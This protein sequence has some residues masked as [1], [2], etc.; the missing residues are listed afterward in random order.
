MATFAVFGV[1]AQ[2]TYNDLQNIC[3]GAAC[4]PGHEDEISRGRTDQTVAKVALV[5]G[6]VGLAGGVTLFVLSFRSKAADHPSDAG[7]SLV[8]GPGWIGLGGTL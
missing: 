2:S 3:H 6:A 8:F 7:A 5:T 1:L 4:P